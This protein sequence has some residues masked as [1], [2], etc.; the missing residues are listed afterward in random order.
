[1][2]N[3]V[4]SLL[5]LSMAA[6]LA[7]GAVGC[8]SKQS[9]ADLANSSVFSAQTLPNQTVKRQGSIAPEDFVQPASLGSYFSREPIF[10][11]VVREKRPVRIEIS[12]AQDTIMLLTGDRHPEF[13]DDVNGLDPALY[14]ELEPGLYH[15]YLGAW[16]ATSGPVPYNLE[17]EILS[18]ELFAHIRETREASMPSHV[19]PRAT[20]FEAIPLNVSADPQWGPIAAVREAQKGSVTI[21]PNSD[22]SQL[23][24]AQDCYGIIDASRP[25]AVVSAREPGN[26]IEITATALGSDLVMA[27]VDESGN[28]FCNDDFNGLDPGVIVEGNSPSYRVFLG[29]FNPVADIPAE[30]TVRTFERPPVRTVRSTVAVGAGASQIS[31]KGDLSAPST[32]GDS[33]SGVFASTTE[34][35]AVIS[36]PAGHSSMEFV[37]RSSAD[38]TI[39]VVGPDGSVQC[40]DD[41][42]GLNAAISIVSPAAGD[43]KV[44]VGNFREVRGST[45]T[46]D[47]RPGPALST[48][49]RTRALVVPNGGSASGAI[50]AGGSTNASSVIESC[51]GFFDFSA[52]A[53]TVEFSAAGQSTWS[54][55]SN[56]DSVLLIRDSQGSFTCIDDGNG[57][58]PYATIEIPA[59]RAH[60]WLGTFEQ[61]ARPADATLRVD[62]GR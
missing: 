13:I 56:T 25:V 62:T 32:F 22:L 49:S 26:R 50:R 35:S 61:I 60:V 21:T 59:G 1:M 18:D 53:A 4:V 7:V 45:S 31:L 24:G 39:V 57:V 12:S 46:L 34:P 8:G 20:D 48:N 17:V 47:V 55:E 14:E 9:V 52:P 23:G 2:R 54:V 16:D 28:Y 43:Y 27:V 38:P 3:S 42:Y 6:G 10:S 19:D 37:A 29:A 5:T 11:F 58:N 30:V 40:N 33:C 15:I 36:L 44:F 41:A 51:N